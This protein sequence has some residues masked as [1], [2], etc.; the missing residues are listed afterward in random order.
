[1]SG[2]SRCRQGGCPDDGTITIML[3]ELTHKGV[4]Q[5]VAD[6]AV[7]LQLSHPMELEQQ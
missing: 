5:F 2:A 7:A 4:Q 6:L 1:M 3:R